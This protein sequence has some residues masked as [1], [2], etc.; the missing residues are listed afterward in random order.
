[1]NEIYFIYDNKIMKGTITEKKSDGYI[2]VSG[3]EVL[4]LPIT[5]PR[6]HS[7]QEA[8]EYQAGYYFTP[9]DN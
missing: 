2:V 6:F 9:Q 4:W 5:E 1:M 7:E 8:L 3:N